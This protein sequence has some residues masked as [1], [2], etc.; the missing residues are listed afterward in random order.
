MVSEA[1]EASEEAPTTRARKILQI[2]QLR[3]AIPVIKI[4]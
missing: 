1:R 3:F 2:H 4:A